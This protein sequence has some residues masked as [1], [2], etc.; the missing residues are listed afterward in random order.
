MR[1][2]VNGD[3]RELPERSTVA[4]A[5][6]L[7][8]LGLDVTRHATAIKERIGVQLQTAALFPQLTVAEVIDLFGSFYDRRLPTAQCRRRGQEGGL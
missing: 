4:D 3:P 7:L 1:V 6:D 5:G 8:V 2:L